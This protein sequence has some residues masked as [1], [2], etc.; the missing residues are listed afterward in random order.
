M[1]QSNIPSP[2][3]SPSAI[4]SLAANL[5][6]V[7]LA[8]QLAKQAENSK[9]LQ[10]WI[11][12]DVRSYRILAEELSFFLQDRPELLWRFPA[13]EVLPYDRVSPHH[14]IVGERFA[15]LGKLL[16]QP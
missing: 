16:H 8:Y 7:G 4:T 14:A 5:A 9:Q 13:W 11:C 2:T 15:T 6:Q 1:N 3:T 10:V 12:P